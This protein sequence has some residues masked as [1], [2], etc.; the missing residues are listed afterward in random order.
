MVQAILWIT[1]KRGLIG[2]HPILFKIGP[3]AVYSWGFML[4]VAI[5]VGIWGIGNLFAKE[6]YDKEKVLDM[7]LIMVIA[8]LLGGRIAFILF[9]AWADFVVH[10]L[11]FF[12]YRSGGLVWYGAF[13][14]GFL[15]FLIYIYKSGLKFWPVA[16]MFA[17]YLALGYA[18]VRIGCFMWGCCYGKV[19]SSPLG[20]VFPGVDNLT[21][22]PTQLFSS[23]LNFILFG[24][25]ITYFPKRKFSGQVFLLY[26][27]GYSI[28]RFSIEFLRFNEILYWGLS[29]AQYISIGLFI[30][31]AILYIQRHSHTL[32]QA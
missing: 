2:M 28:Y 20:V 17:P 4:A 8:G 3:L 22:Y 21:R 15:A 29:L 31:A 10:P 18:I 19:T 12:A 7:T 9:F 32:A 30:V 26:L 16:D 1:F 14:G 23:A 27:I 25:L 24:L 6:G 5:I 13:T 11:M